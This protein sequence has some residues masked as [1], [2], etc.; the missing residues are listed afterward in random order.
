MGHSHLRKRVRYRAWVALDDVD[1]SN[2]CMRMVR[3]SYHWGS[4]MPFLREI[5]DIHTMPDRFE[6][7]DVGGGTLSRAEGSCALSSR[8][9][10][11]RIA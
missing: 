10:V 5:P 4:Q 9:D 3:G 8:L 11:A 7:N 6:D 2:G 1:E